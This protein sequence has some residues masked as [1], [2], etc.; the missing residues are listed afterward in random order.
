MDRVSCLILNC[1]YAIFRPSAFRYRVKEGAVRSPPISHKILLL[2]LQKSSSSLYALL[3]ASESSLIL[4]LSGTAA[5]NSTSSSVCFCKTSLRLLS[6]CS[7]DHL[8]ISLLHL[9]ILNSTH[10]SV[11]FFHAISMIF[12]AST[13]S[14]SLLSYLKGLLLL[15]FEASRYVIKGRWS[16]PSNLR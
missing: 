1:R 4:L 8:I 5:D 12:L 16:E 3:S 6:L 15:S 7:L 14:L 2:C 10:S 9:E 11:P 13:F